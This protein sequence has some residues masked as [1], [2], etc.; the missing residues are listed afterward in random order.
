MSAEFFTQ[1]AKLVYFF[2]QRCPSV[3]REQIFHQY[4]NL[5]IDNIVILLTTKCHTRQYLKK[6]K[7]SILQT[8]RI[9]CQA[10]F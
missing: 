7:S 3:F 9:E 6:K 5:Y 2:K 8:I 10:L 1:Y 4:R